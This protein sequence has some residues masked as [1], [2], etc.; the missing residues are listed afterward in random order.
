MISWGAVSK[1]ALQ[2]SEDIWA[3]VVVQLTRRT[4]VPETEPMDRVLEIN[5]GVIPGY[6]GASRSATTSITLA[7]LT[8]TMYV[9]SS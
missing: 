3:F 7:L 8:T 9:S 6:W 5:S 1:T 2:M 4:P